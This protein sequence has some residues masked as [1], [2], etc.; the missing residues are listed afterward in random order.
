MGMACESAEPTE[1]RELC[2]LRYL[3]IIAS[4]YAD[5][6]HVHSVPMVRMDMTLGD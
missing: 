2:E 1:G 4:T 5:K 3:Y 6:W